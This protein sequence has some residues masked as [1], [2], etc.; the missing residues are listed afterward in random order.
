M[1]SEGRTND[2]ALL[3]EWQYQIERANRNNVFCHCRECDREWVD[4][5]SRAACPNCGSSNVERIACWQFPD[6]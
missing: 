6:D 2:N 3:R 5:N 4:S 1:P